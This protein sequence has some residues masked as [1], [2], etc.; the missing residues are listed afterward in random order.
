MGVMWS[1][2]VRLITVSLPYR[3][4]AT[5]LPSGPDDFI[6]LATPL[7]FLRR[8][9]K[10]MLRDAVAARPDAELFFGFPGLRFT[11]APAAQPG[12]S[13]LRLA[14]YDG[15]GLPLVIRGAALA[16]LGGI[17][18]ELGTGAAYELCLR[19]LSC[20]LV[21]Q[22]L[23][24]HF[25]HLTLPFRLDAPMRRTVVEQWN[26]TAGG[27]WRIAD[28]A[29]P[30][31]L[32]LRRAFTQIP[33][34]SVIVGAGPDGHGRLAPVLEALARD[35][36][37]AGHLEVVADARLDTSGASATGAVP[38][39]TVETAGLD[40]PGRRNA[41]W[42]AAAHEHLVFLDAGLTPGPTDLIDALIGLAADPT[43]G[44]AGGRVL[45]ESGGRANDG[46]PGTPAGRD[47]PDAAASLFGFAPESWPERG[48]IHREYAVPISPLVA[49]RRSALAAIGGFAASVPAPF[50][51][52]E[53]ALRMRL[54]GLSMVVT[55][56]AWATTGQMDGQL[57]SAAEAEGFLRRWGAVRDADR[58]TF[59]D[60]PLSPPR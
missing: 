30:G 2:R 44:M 38:W 7:T 45:G 17:R 58:Q 39:R 3:P 60:T 43:V 57:V 35:G 22:Q 41:L 27:P 4:R 8:R 10:R 21:A 56:F 32:Q 59:P 20:G 36:W 33:P 34:V 16:A 51:L 54:L 28:G 6:V 47:R 49:T 15:I 37:P 40:A 24:V 50:L 52:A 23:P 31:T 48:F 12:A 29:R 53:A 11:P 46:R 42:R 13:V 25:A 19:A 9:L 18:P 26:A 14:A 1:G 5:P 55:P